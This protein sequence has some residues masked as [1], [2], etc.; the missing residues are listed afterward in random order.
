MTVLEKINSPADLKQ[1]SMAELTVLAEEMRAALIRKVDTTGG[2]MGPNLGMIEATIALHYVFDAPSDKIVFD[3]SHQSYPHKMLTGR[4]EAFTDPEKYGSVSGLKVDED[5]K[6]I[7]GAVFGLFSNDENEYTRENAYMVTES[8]EDGTFKFEKIPYG[9]WVVREIEPAVGFVLNEK[10]YQITI[11]EDGD[12]VE[13][14]VPQGVMT[15]EIVKI[16]IL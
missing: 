13:I 2:H 10:A 5:G 3:V 12:V 15:F 9:T 7:K 8:A 14:K 6:V 4:R 11:Q 1:L 16:E